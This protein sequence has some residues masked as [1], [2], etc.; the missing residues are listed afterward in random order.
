MAV[1]LIAEIGSVHDGSYGN[2]RK[3]IE[4]AA[5]CGADSVKFQ[6]HISEAET[7]ANAPAPAYF[8]DESRFA[9]FERTAFSIDQWRSLKETAA[10]CGVT[11]L[12]SP[13]SL[14]AVDLLEKIDVSAYKIPS[15]EVTNLPLLE[16]IAATGKRALLSSGMSDWQELDSAVDILKSGGPLCVMQCSS[17]YPCPPDQ[18][19]LN[20]ISEIRERFGVDVGFSDHTASNAASIAAVTMGAV[21]VEKHLTFSKLMYGSDA[22]NAAE[23]D[24]FKALAEALGEVVRMLASPVD[25]DDMTPYADMKRIF[26]KS[27]VAA[28]DLE[29]GTSLA[30][31]DLAF[32]KPGDGISAS[33]YKHLVGRRL[34]HGVP[35]DHIFR[36]DDFEP[37]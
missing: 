13:F 21:S 24:Q 36:T 25:K 22:K 4:L 31:A 6:T 27:I 34:V 1:E 26:Q 15:G 8:T 30:L 37:G 17:A 10:A 32:K 2:A 3:L 28:R 9:Y 19:G 16:K 18:V 12:S 20:V 5:M 35:S 29:A 7:T 23:P 33:D 14:E 11:F